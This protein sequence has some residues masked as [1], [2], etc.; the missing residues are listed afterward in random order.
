MYN[1]TVENV[2]F[3]QTRTQ[4]GKVAIK[5]HRPLKRIFIWPRF[6]LLEGSCGQIIP[7]YIWLLSSAIL[8]AQ[9]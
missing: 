4:K 3:K 7:V 1:K 6:G 2:H 9:D 8:G 5:R